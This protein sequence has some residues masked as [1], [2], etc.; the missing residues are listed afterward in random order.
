MKSGEIHSTP[1]GWERA[2][3]IIL[4]YII[5]VGLFQ[6]IGFKL[7]SFDPMNY[8]LLRDPGQKL[9]INLFSLT[10]TVLITVL[11]RQFADKESIRSMGFYPSGFWKETC[12]GFALGALI[13]SLGFVSLAFLKEITWIG[14]IPK[15]ADLF[16]S[17]C[18]FVSIAIGE[19]LLNRGYILNNLMKSMHPLL[20]LF[21]SSIFFSLMHIFNSNYSWISLWNLL[22]AGIL[23]G[24]VYI[25][26][27]NLWFPI[28]LHFSWNFFQGTIFGFNVSGHKG[29]SIV[30]QSRTADN[31]WNGGQFGFEGSIFATIFQLVVTLLLWKYYG[32]RI[33][34]SLIITHAKN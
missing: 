32:K 33:G 7:I 29:Y 6:I 27:Q 11:F 3:Q 12:A 21:I 5:V 34:K 19:E 20:A 15:P 1:R 30:I 10:G 26:T 14:T 18:L 8:Q 25:L 23:L 2:L 16:F 17:L 31:I 9:V 4:P 28:A 24:L 22:L 13:I